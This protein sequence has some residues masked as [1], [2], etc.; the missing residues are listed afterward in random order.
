M[1]VRASCHVRGSPLQ[2][3]GGSCHKQMSCVRRL[4]KARGQASK[5]AM[6][7]AKRKVQREIKKW[8]FLICHH[9]LQR[10]HARHTPKGRT[11]KQTRDGIFTARQKSLARV[12]SKGRCPCSITLHTHM[13]ERTHTHRAD[14]KRCARPF[15][16]AFARVN[17][18]LPPLPSQPHPCSQQP[19]V[20]TVDTIMTHD[21]WTDGYMAVYERNHRSH[22]THIFLCISHRTC[23]RR[24]EIHL[25]D[26]ST[27]QSNM[28]FF[29]PRQNMVRTAKVNT[30][31][32]SDR[33]S[34]WPRTVSLML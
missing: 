31:A 12:G 28:S 7:E 11:S 23:R 32:S 21:P 17:Q 30:V 19:R 5:R 16:H 22:R 6:L 2:G 18:T 14:D 13:R 24:S 27:R 8:S 25:T 1:N 33:L 4:N 34:E 10:E 9:A 15:S 26:F 3:P 29:M 20:C